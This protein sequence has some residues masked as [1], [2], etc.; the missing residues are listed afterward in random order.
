[1]A[2]LVYCTLN[3]HIPVLFEHGLDKGSIGKEK[4]NDKREVVTERREREDAG[5][6]MTQSIV[7]RRPNSLNII[8][9]KQ[10]HYRPGKGQRVPGS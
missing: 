3:E 8:K 5:N 6:C 4:R 7:I 2:R 10:S 9:V 1:M